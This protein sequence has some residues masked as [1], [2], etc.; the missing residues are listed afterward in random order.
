M[1][2]KPPEPCKPEGR[3]VMDASLTS[4]VVCAPAVM[5]ANVASSVFAAAMSRLNWAC[6][7]VQ[8][9]VRVEKAKK[10]AHKGTH[11][12]TPPPFDTHLAGLPPHVRREDLC[13]SCDAWDGF[14]AASDELVRH[15]PRPELCTPRQP[16]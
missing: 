14:F 10:C 6:A 12:S 4:S 8:R 9:H 3:C 5:L 1:V 7:R 13:P 16:S 11:A 2:P 15:F